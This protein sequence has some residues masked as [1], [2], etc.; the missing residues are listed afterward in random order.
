MFLTGVFIL[1]FYSVVIGWIFNYV[2]IAATDLPTNVTEAQSVF[3][4][5]LKEDTFTQLFYYTLAFSVI[6]YTISKGVKNGIE[7]LNNILMPALIIILLIMLVYSMRL[8]G[9]FKPFNLCFIPM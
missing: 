9:F 8:D 7:R 4:N 3:M 1:S 2:V 6:A 5:L